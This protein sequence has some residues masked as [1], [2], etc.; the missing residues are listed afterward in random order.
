MTCEE[1][2]FSLFLYRLSYDYSSWEGNEYLVLE[3]WVPSIHNE[4]QPNENA[5]Q[6]KNNV[7]LV[8]K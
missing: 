7:A 4:V 5:Q 6:R 3:Y 2:Y 8:D 1:K